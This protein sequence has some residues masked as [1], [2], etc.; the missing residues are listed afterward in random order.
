MSVIRYCLIFF[1]GFSAYA[2]IELRD[3]NA[4]KILDSVTVTKSSGNSGN[5]IE[6]R[7]VDGKTRNTSDLVYSFSN[8]RM[9]SLMP[10]PDD[11]E[12][13]TLYYTFLDS[14]VFGTPST[15]VISPGLNYLLSSAISQTTLEDQGIF[16]SVMNYT[17]EWVKGDF[18]LPTATHILLGGDSLK[19]IMKKIGFSGIIAHND[20]EI[21]DFKKAWLY[22][23][24]NT[25]SITETTAL[26]KHVEVIRMNHALVLKEKGKYTWVFVNDE[27]ITDGP[28]KLRWPSVQKVRCSHNLL[29]VLH[30]NATKGNTSIYVIDYVNGI[31]GKLNV[32]KIHGNPVE[33]NGMDFELIKGS[34]ILK[35]KNSKEIEIGIS[36]IKDELLSLKRAE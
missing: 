8:G 3:L 27:L 20:R 16:S 5:S 23:A 9:I 17:V 13:N 2:Q 35:T 11:T 25:L 6:I 18:S 28:E 32:E 36:K 15:S 4:D 10:V 7:V 30:T 1:A 33:E 12:R 19:Q 24:G 22:F 26:S 14:T 29:F 31:C 21:G 34:L